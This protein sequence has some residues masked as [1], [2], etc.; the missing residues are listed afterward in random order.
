MTA[1]R[2]GCSLN[3]SVI[4]DYWSN[5]C[6]S[7]FHVTSSCKI[8]SLTADTD[9]VRKV[10]NI[11]RNHTGHITTTVASLLFHFGCLSIFFNRSQGCNSC[12]VVVYWAC[13]LF[14]P[15]ENRGYR[16][17]QCE[18]I[19]QSTLGENTEQPGNIGRPLSAQTCCT[20]T[21][22]NGRR[23]RRRGRKRWGTSKLIRAASQSPPGY[24]KH[25]WTW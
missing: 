23:R 11:A 21:A 18:N 2:G 22:G 15:K 8:F 24:M 6:F 12:N 10:G 13:L 9:T 25:W 16:I 7:V 1:V 5:G 14:F 17:F 4:P 19:L 3:V 20:G